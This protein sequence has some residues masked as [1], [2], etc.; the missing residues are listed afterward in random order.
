MISDLL[1]TLVFMKK[2]IRILFFLTQIFPLT[3]IGQTSVMSYNIRYD[4]PNDN[5]NWWQNRKS[6]VARMINYY[7][8]E[9]IGIQEGLNNQV[10]Y[11]DST[12]LGYKYVGVGRDDGKLKGEYTAIFYKTESIKALSTKT[13]W[14]SETP[15]KVSTGW[16]ASME[17][18]VTFG[19]FLN[20]KTNDTLYVFN[21]HYDHKGKVAQEKS[22]DLILK[23]IKDKKITNKKIILLGDFN[24]ESYEVPIKK[25]QSLLV[26]NFNK[27]YVITYGPLGTFN[28][29]KTDLEIKRRIDYIFTKNINVKEYIHIDDR[30]KNNLH[31]SDH[32][33]VLIKIE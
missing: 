28:Q 27:K 19:A 1:N 25:F 33:P 5:E 10:K 18:I 7:A 20:K 15:D 8:P 16:D 6:E 13:F 3:L 31:L 23:I 2:H 14:L 17:R 26:D 21:C 24:S 32:L 9:I 30:R 11:L 12:L 22:T 29:F 4:N